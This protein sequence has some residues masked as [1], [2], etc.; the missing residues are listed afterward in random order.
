MLV[1]RRSAHDNAVLQ[2][3]SILTFRTHC[4]TSELS[5]TVLIGLAVKSHSELNDIGPTHYSKC[6]RQRTLDTMLAAV[7]AS[8]RDCSESS[9][10]L[11]KFYDGQRQYRLI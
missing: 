9:S 4:R 1:L 2:R 7:Y 6:G 3:W 11:E 5:L 10:W 8:R